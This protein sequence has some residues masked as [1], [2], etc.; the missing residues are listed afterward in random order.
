MEHDTFKRRVLV[1]GLIVSVLFAVCIYA[2]QSFGNLPVPPR[3]IYSFSSSKTVGIMMLLGPLLVVWAI[4]VHLRCTDF[5]VTR[6]LKVIAGLFAFWLLVVLLKYSLDDDLLTSILWYCYYLPMLY[7]PVLCLFSAFR[8]ASWDGKP[9][10]RVIKRI[11][12]TISTLLLLLVFTNNAHQAVF[13]FDFSDPA[14]SSNYR[15]GGGYWAVLGWSVLLYVAYFVVLFP[16][17]RVQ[18]RSTFSPVMALGAAGIAYGV[19]YTLRLPMV[20]GS[21]FALNYILFVTLVLELSLDLGILPSYAWHREVFR[22]LPLDL[23]VLSA[24]LDTA[25]ATQRAKPLS[26]SARAA[27]VR[28][29]SIDTAFATFKDDD[30]P[31]TLYKAYRLQGGMA[32][33][34]ED[35]SSIVERRRYLT[36][37]QEKLRRRNEALEQNR[38]V[39]HRLYLQKY[40]GYLFEEVEKSLRSTV[41]K[42]RELLDG[43]PDGQDSESTARRRRQLMEIKL[44]VAYCKRK[45][46]LVLAESGEPDFDRARLQLATNESAADLRAAG[47]DCAVLVEVEAPLSAL[48]V[49]MLYDG[50][51]KFAFAAFRFEKPALMC[52]I[53]PHDVDHVEMRVV[54]D[55]GVADGQDHEEL[56][57]ELRALFDALPAVYRISCSEESWNLTLVV[58]KQVV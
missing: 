25:F 23:K 29:V 37:Q 16:A 47:I 15:Y 22:T 52:V 56:F 35:V 12:L 57:D 50:F 51:Y 33:L 45:G 43:L 3:N 11:V 55:T 19:L 38:A 49:S 5:L 39:Q 7:V 8:A 44:L 36:L 34:T 28:H 53:R 18:L 54:L 40:E 2:F 1:G 41:A 14:W 42:I 9:G 24:N 31:L 20:I 17:A 46:A 4:S 48:T 10:V 32:L 13:S 6:Y 30:D 26:D 58:M 27:I 21:N